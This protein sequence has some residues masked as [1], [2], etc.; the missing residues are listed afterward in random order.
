MKRKMVL[1]NSMILVVSLLAVS[2][3]AQSRLDAKASTANLGS[4]LDVLRF[5]VN[6]FTEQALTYGAS[7]VTYRLYRHIAYVANP[8][9][10]NYESLDVAVP[11]EINGQ[12]I[13]AA[14]APILL[15]VNAGGYMS[16]SNI[17]GG[18]GR[19][20]T[21]TNTRDALVAGF[22]VVVP[23][24]R[25]RDQPVLNSTYYGKAPAGIVD[26]K[27]V[28]RYIHYNK[29]VIPGNANWIVAA[30]I[31][32]GGALSS[33]LGASCD[34]NLYD[35]ALAQI[36]A[37]N[38]SDAIFASAPY[39]PIT[40]LDHAD[41]AY[42]WEFGTTPLSGSLVNQSISQQLKNLFST[43]QASLKLQGKTAYG[44][45]TADNYGDYLVK[46]Y[47]IPSANKYLTALA[48]EDRATYLANRT[49][50]TWS[51][52]SALFTWVDYVAYI[53]RSKKL[54]AFDAFDLSGWENSLF[55]NSTT[56]ARHFTNFSLQQASGNPNALLDADLPTTVNMMNPM[57][58]IMQNYSGCAQYW[59]IRSGT[60][61]TDTAHT[62]FGNLAA[63]L[64]NRGKNVNASLYWDGGHGVNQDPEVFVAWVRQITNYSIVL[65]SGGW[66]RTYGGAGDDK[67]WG[68]L[69]QT[70]D[71][72]Y[73]ISGDTSSFGAGGSDYWLI[74]IDAAGNGV[75]NKTYGG[76]LTESENAMVQTIDGGFAMAGNTNSF[77]AGSN[78]FWLVK[79]DA[80]GNKQWNKTYGG[81]GS[82]LAVTVFQTSDGGFAIAGLTSSFGAGGMDA[83]LVKTDSAGNMQWNKTYGGTGA[84]YAFSVV[85][86]G[87]GGYAVSGPTASFGAGSMDVWLFKTDASGNMVWNK[88]YGGTGYEWMDQMIKTADGG[89]AISGYT[90]SFGAGGTDVWLVKADAS[91]NMQWNKT[92]GGT[93]NDN[94]FHLLQETGGGYVIVGSTLSFGA[95]GSDV[96]LIKTD[97]SGSML[98]NQTYGGTGSDVGSSVVQASNGGYALAGSTS[99]FGAGSNDFYVIKV[100]G[101]G[102]IPEFSSWLIPTLALTSTGML[103]IRKKRRLRMH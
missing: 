28:V 95:G 6:N 82:D 24:L 91:G 81:N 20:L 46:T 78:D 40:D 100:D 89:Y 87:D 39:C 65:T 90:S 92:Y 2:F 44:N 3:V 36:G 60:K 10:L 102:V 38:S 67:G 53:G 13:D 34:S 77:G 68:D 98:W 72:E 57:Y 35:A 83:W 19:L 15:V 52:N 25:G 94:G 75:W 59:F 26:L 63:S 9:D 37:A 101:V 31:S 48:N 32:G 88:T 14:N 23:G 22:V 71:G 21:S 55:G 64:E 96:W 33:L 58:F 7:N 76:N 4:G 30:G 5:P 99:S 97:S 42:E 84:D 79:T 16:S 29:G 80:A 27:A 56:N 41:M 8:V 54:P 11:V 1:L 61:D 12:D 51:N 73:V 70:S 62:I 86:T 47:L 18:A 85:Q 66:S 74:K 93:A 103:L 17:A 45:L 50:I 43:Y 49:W 69:V